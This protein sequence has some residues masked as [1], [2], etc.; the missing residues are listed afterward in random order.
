MRG[1]SIDAGHE[2]HIRYILRDCK[3]NYSQTYA[4]YLAQIES[5]NR[6]II[7]S[8]TT[9]RGEIYP[10]WWSKVPCFLDIST[11]SKDMIRKDDLPSKF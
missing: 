6:A 10:T 9:T 8:A 7:S 1:V 3:D 2:N 5:G 4:A 11:L